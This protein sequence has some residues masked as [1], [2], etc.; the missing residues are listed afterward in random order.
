M[1]S[2]QHPLENPQEHLHHFLVE[3]ALATLRH[4]AN[5]GTPRSHLEVRMKDALQG[6]RE[7]GATWVRGHIGIPGN[8]A[9]DQEASLQGTLGASW[10]GMETAT[11]E[12]MKGKGRKWRRTLRH[13]PGHGKRRTEWG[14][15]ALA[16]YTWSRTNRGPQK[17]WLHHIGKVADPACPCGHPVQDGDH[18]VFHCPTTAELRRR[19]L[20]PGE[21]TWESLDD[22]HWVMRAG[23]SGR[24]QEKEEGTEAF[25]QDLHRL[26]RQGLGEE[27]EEEN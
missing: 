13:S 25:F 10:G 2:L 17:A 24:E 12:G 19:Y 6:D 27:E 11:F 9:A 15:H 26:M 20:P 5:G 4:L 23:G 21:A 1:V 16:A 18:L 8:E 14:K 22:P 3:A 7:V